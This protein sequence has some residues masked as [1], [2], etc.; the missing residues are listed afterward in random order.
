MRTKHSIEKA[1]NFLNV[2]NHELRLHPDRKIDIA[3]ISK[4]YNIDNRLVYLATE[5]NYFTK[6][7]T[8]YVSNVDR[9][10]PIDARKILEYRSKVIKAEQSKRRQRETAKQQRIKFKAQVNKPQIKKRYVSIFWG[11]IK[12]SY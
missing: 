6:A 10:D 3:G 4:Q 5:L 11:L 1:T 12:Y 7:A 8:G 9:I 2:V